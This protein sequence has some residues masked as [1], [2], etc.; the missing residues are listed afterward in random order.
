MI[1]PRRERSC[2]KSVEA[3]IC[4]NRRFVIACQQGT[5]VVN[6]SFDL[7]RVEKY[8]RPLV[9]RG[10]TVADGNHGGL[11]QGSASVDG[12]ST[13]SQTFFDN[14]PTGTLRQVTRLVVPDQGS[15]NYELRYLVSASNVGKCSV[16]GRLLIGGKPVATER[17][18]L[19][20]DSTTPQLQ[21]REVVVAYQ[22]KPEDAK[23]SIS[24]E[25]AFATLE[26]HIQVH[27]DEVRL[28]EVNELEP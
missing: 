7:P 15:T 10:W 23:K 5:G 12:S 11:S 13:S 2:G 3:A 17:T 19:D 27:L 16:E 24:I 21:F 6:G 18:L 20:P 26:P 9:P 1:W 28:E 25:F 4:K 14:E 22:T 8:L